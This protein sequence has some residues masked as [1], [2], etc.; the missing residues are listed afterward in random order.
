MI[1]LKE[2][3]KD[4]CNCDSDCCSPIVE[5]KELGGAFI[6]RIY[7]MTDRNDHNG[8]RLQLAK[9]AKSKYHEKFYQAISDLHDLYG[10]MPP[11]LIKLRNKM[12]PKFM[13]HLKNTFSNYDAIHGAL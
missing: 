9:L 13:K 4:E 10:S 12:E 5:R 6:D 7:D 8:A 3:I 1:K 11:E 2:L